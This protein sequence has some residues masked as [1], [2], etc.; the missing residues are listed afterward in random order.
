MKTNARI[1]LKMKNSPGYVTVADF[2]AEGDA[3]T[4]AAAWQL[5][6]QVERIRVMSKIHA[7][8]APSRTYW[9]CQYARDNPKQPAE[10]IQ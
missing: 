1:D 3:I 6:P 8:N 7:Y 2:A 4:A 10:A 5:G 9:L